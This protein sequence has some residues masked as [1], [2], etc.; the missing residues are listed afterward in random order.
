MCIHKPIIFA[1]HV[2]SLMSIPLE[3]TSVATKIGA[4]P[5]KSTS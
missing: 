1:T 5:N 3:A 2:M 4:T